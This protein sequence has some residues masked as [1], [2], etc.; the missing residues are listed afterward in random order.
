MVVKH[1]YLSFLLALFLALPVTAMAQEGEQEG[2]AAPAPEGAEAAE[3]EDEAPAEPAE[4]EE[5][6]AP[7]PEPEA[8]PEP[9]PEPEVSALESETGDPATTGA[10][11]T[12]SPAASDDEG[13]AAAA[14]G[15]EGEGEGGE[16][17]APPEGREGLRYD[18]ETGRWV[19]DVEPLPW[20]NTLFIWNNTATLDTFLPEGRRSYNPTY[21]QTF[22]LRPRWYVGDSQSIRLRENLTWE[23]TPQGDSPASTYGNNSAVFSDLQL[24]VFDTSIF[25]LPGDVA[26]G[27]GVTGFAPVSIA[28]RN[29][30]LIMGL[31]GT[32]S[33]TKVFTDIMTGLTVQAFGS[34][35][36][37]FHTGNAP[38]NESDKYGNAT[39]SNPSLPPGVSDPNQIGG[40]TNT[41]LSGNIGLYAGLAPIPELSFW[42]QW[43]NQWN[44]GRGLADA[45]VP[46]DSAPGGTMVLEDMSQ[47]HTRVLTYFGVGVSWLINAWIN[48]TF[49]YSSYNSSLDGSGNIYNPFYNPASVFTLQAVLILDRVYEG[50]SNMLSGDDEESE[51]AAT[52]RN[53]DE[54]EDSDGEQVAALRNNRRAAQ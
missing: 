1:R 5:E 22:S 8:A 46:V 33:A 3:T 41:M 6:A 53:E 4:E 29:S 27:G 43:Q 25:M 18:L 32:F 20:R 44:L 7:A 15:G 51:E 39:A 19:E 52:A 24:T 35:R 31:Q 23:L 37:N 2:E 42:A 16:G 49:S 9:E 17:E 36:G 10:D 14:A 11:G 28:S 21:L 40:L 12:D 47:T 48:T 45:T 38:G 30:G 34:F 26:I 54:E 13:E 50:V